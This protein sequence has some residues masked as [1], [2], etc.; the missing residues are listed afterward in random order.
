MLNSVVIINVV[1]L[2][3]VVVLRDYFWIFAISCTLYSSL[4][5][6]LTRLLLLLNLEW[7]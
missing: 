5:K 1:V 6:E 4:R 3:R 7:M 2:S